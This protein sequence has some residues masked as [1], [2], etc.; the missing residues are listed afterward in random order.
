MRIIGTTKLGQCIWA[1]INGIDNTK[2]DALKAAH[3]ISSMAG[4]ERVP[5][6][7]NDTK[8]FKGSVDFGDCIMLKAS[9]EL[10]VIDRAV[11]F[12]RYLLVLEKEENAPVILFAHSQGG[13]ILEHALEFLTPIERAS[14]RVFTFGG[15]SFIAPGKSHFDSHNYASVADY[16]CLMGSPNLQTL[17]L[18]RYHAY[19]EGLTD[20]Q[21]IRQWALQDAILEL[22]SI[23]SKVIKKF[24]EAR[25]GHYQDM[26]SKINNL[27][28]LDPDPD[29][30][31]KHEFTSVC[32]QNAVRQI[33]QKYRK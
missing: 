19:K 8:G 16:V 15:G 17:A 11:K 13:I 5:A 23:D 7:Q 6:M 12:L 28:I 25:V 9:L 26:F 30:R 4:G 32:Y 1:F 29:S 33:I 31:W 24:A 21:M 2:Q 10:P 22:D 27:A 20:V 18:K 3:N 14:L